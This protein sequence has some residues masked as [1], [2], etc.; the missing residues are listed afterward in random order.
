MVPTTNSVGNEEASKR[1]TMDA[2]DVAQDA[3]SAERTSVEV[4][5]SGRH[6]HRRHRHRRRARS[7]HA[8]PASF[9]PSSDTALTEVEDE[10]Q[11]EQEGEEDYNSTSES[12]C[13]STDINSSSSSSS[14][15][16]STM[17]SECVANCYR[18]D[19]VEANPLIIV[20]TSNHRMHVQCARTWVL[21]AGANASC[22]LCRQ[23][24]VFDSATA[25]YQR[26]LQEELVAGPFASEEEELTVPEPPL[27][28]WQRLNR[29]VTRK[30]VYCYVLYTIL[31]AALALGTYAL[32]NGFEYTLPCF[33]EETIDCV[34]R[35]EDNACNYT[36]ARL[37]FFY[38]ID[39][40]RPVVGTLSY[41]TDLC[42]NRCCDGDVL[43]NH[44]YMCLIDKHNTTRI[45]DF[46]DGAS[47]DYIIGVTLIT[48]SVV[49]LTLIAC[50][51]VTRGRYWG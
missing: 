47:R 2:S 13:S 51:C 20:C 1:T 10:E 34:H 46:Y 21:R 11:F 38:T 17:E 43:P 35:C 4:E 32:H 30:H 19:D 49:C 7:S 33:Y 12:D 23:S 31:L 29:S 8:T 18:A 45:H 27:T 40:E 24:S 6:R 36:D 9:F 41:R 50:G 26:P 14:R 28:P 39:D 44:R 3:A 48:V 16:S 5:R 22:P 37:T 42:D 25:I 15:S